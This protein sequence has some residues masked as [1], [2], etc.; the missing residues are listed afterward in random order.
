MSKNE[1]TPSQRSATEWA[2]LVE[3]SKTTSLSL[4]VFSAQAGVSVQHLYHWRSKLK[5]STPRPQRGFQ[6]LKP[7]LDPTA[8]T[9]KEHG[10]IE[11]HLGNGRM[12]RVTGD[13]VDARLL[14][15]MVEI[16]QAG[17]AC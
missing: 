9:T 17:V 16:A 3:E 8:N 10:A 14:Q 15:T 7:R 12:V 2:R 6:E 1:H 11:L 5:A 4:R 13:R